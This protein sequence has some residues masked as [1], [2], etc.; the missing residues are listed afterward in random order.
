MR[1]HFVVTRRYLVYVILNETIVDLGC[2][3]ARLRNVVFK[4][5]NLVIMTKVFQ[6]VLKLLFIDVLLLG[7]RS[8]S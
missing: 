8:L 2:L 3:S 7:R 1:D 5:R 4:E 6:Q